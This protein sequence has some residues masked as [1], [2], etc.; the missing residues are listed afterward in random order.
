MLNNIPEYVINY[1]LCVYGVYTYVCMYVLCTVYV[2]Y[3]VPES[4]PAPASQQPP[5]PVWIG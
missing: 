3:P 5:V 1:K 2:L 4:P